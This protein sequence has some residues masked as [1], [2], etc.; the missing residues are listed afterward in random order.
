MRSKPCLKRRWTSLRWP[1]RPRRCCS[2]QTCSTLRATSQ[3]HRFSVDDLTILSDASL[4]ATQIRRA[5]ASAQ[6]II[7]TILLGLD[8]ERFPHGSQKNREATEGE[9]RTAVIASAALIASQRVLTS[10]ANDSPAR[11]QGLVRDVLLAAKF[12][13]DSPR[14][15]PNVS[16]VP[17]IGHFCG[18]S[19]LGTRKADVVVRLWDGRVLAAECKVSNSQVNSIKRLT[20]D[21]AVKARIWRDDFGAANIVPCAVLAGV[22]GLRHL[23]ESQERGLTLFLVALDRRDD[24]LHRGDK[25]TDGRCS[26]PGRHRGGRALP[27]ERGAP[28]R[29]LRDRL[30]VRRSGL[31]APGARTRARRRSVGRQVHVQGYPGHPA[32]HPRAGVS[33]VSEKAFE[34]APA[35]VLLVV[36]SECWDVAAVSV[37]LLFVVSHPRG[38]GGLHD[39]TSFRAH[40]PLAMRTL[41]ASGTS[42]RPALSLATHM[43]S[44]RHPSSAPIMSISMS[45]TCPS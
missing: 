28:F 6:R 8:R 10:R 13:E 39:Y 35:E 25:A 38:Q 27:Q 42:G 24:D 37:L 7:A 44:R 40:S 11:Q 23:K 26:R 41:S 30:T 12:V 34:V 22:F 45:S 9:R 19:I 17:E 21:A 18:E 14:K 29:Q 16:V 1:S 4:S 3:A 36:E 33:S 20:N 5:P 15:I 43:I 2:I 32:D 31:G